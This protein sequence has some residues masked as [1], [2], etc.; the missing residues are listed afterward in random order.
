MNVDWKVVG[1]VKMAAFSF[2][3]VFCFHPATRLISLFAR[4]SSLLFAAV[5]GVSS[6]MCDDMMGGRIKNASFSGNWKHILFT[7]SERRQQPSLY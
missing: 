2:S 4:A 1:R 6:R 3:N 5:R 7:H